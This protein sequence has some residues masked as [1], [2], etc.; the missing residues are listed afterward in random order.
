M[1]VVTEIVAWL[2]G[3][4]ER[5]GQIIEREGDPTMRARRGIYSGIADDVRDKWGGRWDPDLNA[6]LNKFR[7]YLARRR[8]QALA[9]AKSCAEGGD[10]ASAEQAAAQAH[11]LGQVWSMFHYTMLDEHPASFQPHAQ[12]DFTAD[13]RKGRT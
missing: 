12:V 6:R 2:Q 11:V 10:A 4:E 3:L 9:A 7:D 13:T 8:E 5:L 1:S